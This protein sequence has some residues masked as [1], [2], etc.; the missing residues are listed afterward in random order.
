MSV[1]PRGLK[2]LRKLLSIKS[3]RT[4]VYHLL[5]HWWSSWITPWSSC[6]VS[7]FTGMNAIRILVR[8]SLWVTVRSECWIWL[9]KT[10][11]KVQAQLRTKF[12]TFWTWELNFT[13]WWGY[14]TKIRSRLRNVSAD[15]FHSL[16]PSFSSKLLAKWQWPFVVIQPVGDVHYATVRL[17]SGGATQIYHLNLLKEWREAKS[18]LWWA[19]LKRSVGTGS[20]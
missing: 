15:N 16:L 10:G 3:I 14:L 11:R 8:L 6:F 5:R 20:A 2:E 4:S 9:K 17:D 7:S 18:P 12:N 1:V 13:H 19:W